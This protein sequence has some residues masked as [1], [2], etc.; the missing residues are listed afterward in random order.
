MTRTASASVQA[1]HQVAA[2]ESDAGTPHVLARQAG[3]VA[4]GAVIAAIMFVFVEPLTLP[5]IV[6][7]YAGAVTILGTTFVA[8]R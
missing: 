4:L 7:A 6:T 2:L 5:W 3:V 8:N 1:D